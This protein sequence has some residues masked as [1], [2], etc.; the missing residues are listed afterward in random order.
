MSYVME[1]DCTWEGSN[2]L[3]VISDASA[4]G[5]V[6][7]LVEAATETQQ[8]LAGLSS[9]ILNVVCSVMMGSALHELGG[10]QLVAVLWV[11]FTE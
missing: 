9:V 6:P 11:Y 3:H 2:S 4:N 5:P 10:V 8:T 1:R 7:T